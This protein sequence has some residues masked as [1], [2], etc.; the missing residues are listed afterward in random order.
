MPHKY[1]SSI[2]NIAYLLLFVFI[3]LS[4]LSISSSKVDLSPN[5]IKEIIVG[6]LRDLSSLKL[7]VLTKINKHSLILSKLSVVIEPD[8]SIKMEILSLEY[9]LSPFLNTQDFNY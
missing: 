1:Q 5:L 6:V 9:S 3:R 7:N 4:E 8:S 2:L